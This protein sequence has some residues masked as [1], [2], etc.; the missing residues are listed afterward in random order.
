MTT[1]TLVLP[2]PP[3]VASP[4]DL[5][6][7]LRQLGIDTGYTLSNFPIGIAAFVVVVTGLALGAG[8][9]VI[10][11]GVAVLA[12]TL[13]AARGFAMAERAWLPAVLG[14]PVPRPAYLRPEGRPVRKLVTPL[15]DPQTWLDV[16]HALVR[17]PFT[18]AG[19]VVTV[20]MWAGALGGLTRGLWDWALPNGPGDR[21]LPELLG[22]GNGATT[23]IIFYTVVGLLFAVVLPFAVRG[24]ALL[25]AQLGRVLLTSRAA[26]QA[27]IGR[28][29][30]GRDAAVAAEAVALRRLERDIH[31]GPQQRLVRLGMD[32]ARA[33][34]QLDRDP[35][36][37][38]DTLGEAAD[39][40]RE[41]LE[42]LRALSRG[43]APPVLADRGLAAALAALAARS[44][45]PVDLAVDLP[46]E[47]LAPVT[48]NTAY[49]V[50]SEA[51]A[52]VAKHSE[53]DL[54]RVVLACD[55]GR[56]RVVVE[57]DGTGGA[58]LAPGHGLAGLADRLQAVDGVLAVDSPRGGPTRL[59]AELPCG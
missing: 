29:S 40:A 1:D 27:E 30:E 6:S 9:L 58:V 2:P 53:A 54:C 15:R 10:W 4:P 18:I 22:L 16:L 43:I 21:D 55:A 23:R 37:A 8:L 49:F 50:V 17:F 52:N 20:T 19:F 44:P 57:D 34:R 39:L 31:D 13:L 12:A 59:T 33:Q 48:E 46:T 47:R 45:V 32:L 56:L 28:L 14:R 36:A 3:A 5:R 35:Q 42:E 7:R 41:T 11:V 26:A 51:L 25:Q 24:I 38:R